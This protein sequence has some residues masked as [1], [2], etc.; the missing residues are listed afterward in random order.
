[1]VGSSYF[2]LPT[3]LSRLIVS[4]LIVVGRGDRRGRRTARALPPRSESVGEFVRL[5]VS[6]YKL[7]WSITESRLY[8]INIVDR[9]TDCMINIRAIL[10]HLLKFEQQ[11]ETA[12]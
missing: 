9:F 10:S 1:M 11:I 7:Y 6:K 4:S 8:I 5:S 12:N 3:E 2:R